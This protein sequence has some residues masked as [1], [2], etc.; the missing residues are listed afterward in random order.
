MIYFIMWNQSPPPL[1]PFLEARTTINPRWMVVSVSASEVAADVPLQSS[2]DS[3]ES[4]YLSDDRSTQ[5][6][7]SARHQGAV[8]IY[9]HV[10]SNLD[11]SF[12]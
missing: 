4:R 2:L 10:G 12:R 9:Y 1:G 5:L 11:V 7:E 3:D 6:N 8:R